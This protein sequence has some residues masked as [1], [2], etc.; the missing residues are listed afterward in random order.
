MSAPRNFSHIRRDDFAISFA[1]VIAES[2]RTVVSPAASPEMPFL[3]AQ[4]IAWVYQL[5]GALSPNRPSLVALED[6][7]GQGLSFGTAVPATWRVTWAS[8]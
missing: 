1:R 5:L 6:A 2:G 4:F 7:F 8:A 3:Y